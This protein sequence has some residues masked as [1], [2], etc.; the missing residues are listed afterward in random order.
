VR[1]HPTPGGGEIHVLPDCHLHHILG[2]HQNQR[3]SMLAQQFNRVPTPESSFSN[4]WG[5]QMDYSFSHPPHVDPYLPTPPTSQNNSPMPNGISNY[6]TDVFSLNDAP[7]RQDINMAPFPTTRPTLFNSMQ[8]EQTD[9]AFERFDFYPYIP[10][11][12]NPKDHIPEQTRPT[13]KCSIKEI[14][15]HQ[16][17]VSASGT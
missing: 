14:G 12:S 2:E 8:L 17:L 15:I 4:G 13:I 6:I 16:P 5:N 7:L 3:I 9:A 11:N 1:R 10:T